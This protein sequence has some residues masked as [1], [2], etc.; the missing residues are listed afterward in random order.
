[1]TLF[2]MRTEPT[3]EEQNVM[4]E[5][6]DEQ[7][8]E[9]P[10]SSSIKDSFDLDLDKNS[11]LSRSPPELISPSREQA[12]KED[13][14]PVYET[15]TDMKKMKIVV[16]VSPSDY[17]PEEP[18]F[19]SD[20]VESIT[21]T[22]ET[23]EE[24][25]E[26][27]VLDSTHAMMEYCSPTR[28]NE[29]EE[30][31]KH[32]RLSIG[33][34]PLVVGESP[35]Q[36]LVSTDNVDKTCN[37]SIIS[38]RE[39]IPDNYAE[40]GDIPDRI[41]P[42]VLPSNADDASA[43][44]QA[45]DSSFSRIDYLSFD[46]IAFAGKDHIDDHKRRQIKLDD[47]DQFEETTNDGS[48]TQKEE[49]FTEASTCSGESTG[50]GKIM[51]AIP[52]P[53]RDFSIS[54]ESSDEKQGD[55]IMDDIQQQ[56]KQQSLFQGNL[57]RGLLEDDQDVAQ[58]ELHGKEQGR[59]VAHLERFESDD[60]VEE[61]ESKHPA[62]AVY[63]VV[64]T[65]ESSGTIEVEKDF[66][67]DSGE[68]EKLEGEK[69]PVEEKL[70]QEPHEGIEQAHDASV[71][72][73]ILER[74]S[75]DVVTVP[76]LTEMQPVN[77]TGFRIGN[78]QYEPEPDE[79][80]EDKTTENSF[81]G[82][83]EV[84]RSTDD[85][86]WKRG[87]LEESLLTASYVTAPPSLETSGICPSVEVQDQRAIY[88]YDAPTY[89]KSDALFLAQESV[90]RTESAS[91]DSEELEEPYGEQKDE[92]DA[93]MQV[94]IAQSH[95]V[96]FE[97]KDNESHIKV[98]EEYQV[99]GETDTNLV[100]QSEKRIKKP[101]ALPEDIVKT[102]S[103][104]DTSAEPTLLAATYDLDSGA[105]S[106][107]VA[108]YDISPDTVEKTVT[109]ESQTKAILSS[110]E[111]DVFES[112]LLGRRQSDIELE[113]IEG[114]EKESPEG[115][116]LSLLQEDQCQ[117]TAGAERVCSPFE[118][119]EDEDL[120]GYVEYTEQ[121]D[122]QRKEFMSTDQAAV[123]GFDF[124]QTIPLTMETHHTGSFEA[125][126]KTNQPDLF[127]AIT[128]IQRPDTFDTV[129]RQQDRQ[130]DY[131]DEESPTF[132]HSSPLSSSEPS[133]IRGHVSPLDQ[134]SL[135]DL[136]QVEQ[137]F[138]HN[139]P[140]QNILLEEPLLS[141]DH[142]NEPY[143]HAN[144]P[145]EVDY[146]PE[147]DDYELQ[148][149][150][151]PPYYEDIE[152][153]DEQPPD[154]LQH[155]DYEEHQD[156]QPSHHFL[157]EGQ[158]SEPEQ[159]LGEA[160]ATLAQEVGAQNITMVHED[161]VY[162]HHA[163]HLEE[164]A[165]DEPSTSEESHKETSSK[166]PSSQEELPYDSI[167]EQ[168]VKQNDLHI[169]TATSSNSPESALGLAAEMSEHDMRVVG[170]DNDDKTESL[171]EDL[172][173]PDLDRDNK[174]IA[175]DHT[176]YELEMPMDEMS[177]SQQL[178][179]FVIE[180]E[181]E[182]FHSPYISQDYITEDIPKRTGRDALESDAAYQMF[183]G[184]VHVPY[185]EDERGINEFEI[186]QTLTDISYPENPE[187]LL[188][189]QDQDE[190]PEPELLALAEANLYEAGQDDML[191]Q[192]TNEHEQKN[193]MRVFEE[194]IGL[195]E[196]FELQPDL[197][198]IERP[199]SPIPDDS[200]R[201]WKEEDLSRRSKQDGDVTKIHDVHFEDSTITGDAELKE[202][203]C[204]FVHTVIE[205]A[206]AKIDE[207]LIS[208]EEPVVLQIEEPTSPAQHMPD[209]IPEITIT[210]H[211]QQ[212]YPDDDDF[213]YEQMRYELDKD[214][215]MVE[216]PVAHVPSKDT[217][218]AGMV[219]HEVD[220][221]EDS[222]FA[223]SNSASADT[224][225]SQVL[226]SQTDINESKITEDMYIPTQEP[227]GSTEPAVTSEQPVEEIITAV[228]TD[229][230]EGMMQ[231]KC[232]KKKN[233]VE[234]YRQYSEVDCYSDLDMEDFVSEEPS[235][236]PTNDNK[237]I[238]GIGAVGGAALDA[239]IILGMGAVG[240]G[241]TTFDI[242]DSPADSGYDAQDYQGREPQIIKIKSKSSHKESRHDHVE[243][244]E[245]RRVERYE[246][247]KHDV[248]EVETK[249][250]DTQDVVTEEEISEIRTL[251]KSEGEAAA[252]CV[253][254]GDREEQDVFTDVSEIH[255]KTTRTEV[256]DK[257]EYV[258]VTTE[259]EDEF[260]IV[261]TE[262][263]EVK[264]T[265]NKEVKGENEVVTTMES[266][267]IGD[268]FIHTQEVTAE[269]K[270]IHGREKQELE[271][272]STQSL[273]IGDETFAI[274]KKREF[275]EEET[276]SE[277][278]E[279]GRGVDTVQM[280]TFGLD[281]GKP[282]MVRSTETFSETKKVTEATQQQDAKETIT[283]VKQDGDE[284]T[285]TER[286]RGAHDESSS[287]D[288]TQA[289]YGESTEVTDKI[290]TSQSSAKEEGVLEPFESES[291]T[292]SS[293]EE[294]TTVIS[295]EQSFDLDDL[296]SPHDEMADSS[297]VDSF[298]TVVA[299][300][301]EEDRLAEISSMTSS[302]HGDLPPPY[303]DIHEPAFSIDV[304]GGDLDIEQD[305]S[306]SG[307]EKFDMLDKEELD[308]SSLIEHKDSP[309]SSPDDS[310]DII[311]RDD[312][313]IGMPLATIT[314]EDEFKDRGSSSSGSKVDI[315]TPDSSEKISTSPVP[316]SPGIL[317][318]RFFS[319]SGEKDD[320]SISSSLL[321]FETL[322]TEIDDKGS[323]ESITLQ[324][325]F[326]PN[327]YGKIT[328]KD[329]MSISSSLAEFER[330]EQVLSPSVSMDKFTGESKSSDGSS[331]SLVEFEKL[332]RIC[333]LDS[334]GK[335]D[336]DEQLVCPSEV[337]SYKSSTSSLAEFEQL[338]SQVMLDQE[339]H[340]EAEKVV[341]MLESGALPLMSEQTSGS[342]SRS[343][344][345]GGST[346]DMSTISQ[347]QLVEPVEITSE[348]HVSEVDESTPITI[349]KD[350]TDRD[351]L[352]EEEYPRY[353]DIV[354]IIREASENVETFDS[355][356]EPDKPEC[357]IERDTH[358]QTIS[359]VPMVE[360]IIET[361]DT[362]FSN[363]FVG[364]EETM[365]HSSVIVPAETTTREIDIDSLQDD[366]SH[367]K[368]GPM[369]SDSLHDQDS[370]MMIST[371]SFEFD[372]V[373]PEGCPEP[374][375]AAHMMDKSMDSLQNFDLMHQSD[376]G[377]G[378]SD[379]NTPFGLIHK[380]A[381]YLGQT[382]VMQ[383]SVDSLGQP[384]IMFQSADSM[385]QSP[386][387]DECFDS[388]GQREVMTES[389]DSLGQ[390]DIMGKSVDSLGQPDI[391]GK[392]VDSLGQPDIMGESVDSLGQPDIMGKSADSLGQPDIMA[393]STDSLGQPDLM[394]KS[395]DSLGQPDPM[396]EST[397]S[398]GQPDLMGKSVD[399]L[400]QPDPMAA[401]V[402][403]LGQPDP[404]AESTDSLGQPDL[405]GK[406]VY[407]LGQPDIMGK[408]VDSLG[409]PDIMAESTDSLGQPDLMEKSVDSLGQA[410]VMQQSVDSL[411]PLDLMQQSV[412]SLGQ[413]DMF[414]QNVDLLVQPGIMMRSVDSLGSPD[415]MQQSTDSLDIRRNRTYR[416]TDSLEMDQTIPAED[417][418]V[419]SSDSL[420]LD[421]SKPALSQES[422]DRDSLP[423]Q[424]VE[425]A[426]SVR[427]EHKNLIGVMEMSMESGAWSQ[428]SSLISTETLKSS[429]TMTDSGRDIMRM[430]ME[431]PEMD[432]TSLVEDK[433]PFIEKPTETNYE[434]FRTLPDQQD[435]IEVY[436]ITESMLSSTST[437][438]S[439]IDPEGNITKMTSIDSEGNISVTSHDQETVILYDRDTSSSKK[440]MTY[441]HERRTTTY[442]PGVGK[443][444]FTVD[445]SRPGTR[446]TVTNISIVPDRPR[447]L[448][449]DL[450]SPQD[451][452]PTQSQTTPS[453][454]SSHSETCYCAPDIPAA[455]SSID[456]TTWK[457]A[458]SPITRGSCP[459][460]NSFLVLA[461]MS[462]LSPGRVGA[463]V[464]YPCMPLIFSFIYFPHVVFIFLFILLKFNI[465]IYY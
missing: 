443:I 235:I 311:D 441:E 8:I 88:A 305:E 268:E 463:S 73:T 69:T 110:P 97:N 72:E 83:T 431:S 183:V 41:E 245:F 200:N 101:D 435:P 453:S 337:A 299:L 169:H 256:S 157:V 355:V 179:E 377:L 252:E 1:M 161:I 80:E 163:G 238:L 328:E 150:I 91:L 327:I 63:D 315:V 77:V 341:S 278:Q 276:Y 426:T 336:S 298:A 2:S 205:E 320:V 138:F 202:H 454:E 465:L 405:M 288:E 323:N 34:A 240:S 51:R 203:A 438:K 209:D 190:I 38:H 462:P 353:Q 392:S 12:L 231:S 339:L 241:T 407:S 297:S 260:G 368:S 397:D 90:D 290:P 109:V 59:S 224:Q 356:E 186:L 255:K 54:P 413:P 85:S 204:E 338:E 442:E 198:D 139:D 32:E 403:S 325:E 147:I 237:D 440:P 258:D 116:G 142:V 408:S 94:N 253:A 391:M 372:P 70:I 375:Q 437:L 326:Q 39:S 158:P 350:T 412:D 354:Q 366:E 199:K 153:M 182:M 166:E 47:E 37:D 411:G 448:E 99:V 197:C 127:D 383:Q 267:K 444:T 111:D 131:V 7:S 460:N 156:E 324:L 229:S 220:T 184:P 43:V 406:S 219:I 449:Q 389:V 58:Q 342:D 192:N 370:V 322:E 387:L 382:D 361:S 33:D 21:I 309:I 31:R 3:Q 143:A 363:A 194:L 23:E 452:S 140:T 62:E 165:P 374:E 130:T 86:E 45:E 115:T 457:S 159:P 49:L 5:Q 416:S 93:E 365:L 129:P 420:D 340:A 269:T 189:E 333:K 48:L 148:Q 281:S 76:E 265:E 417:I 29:V 261:K 257:K 348:E 395:V 388:F 344:S 332:E 71:I 119:V 282:E 402:D 404:M 201:I 378:Q 369:D 44:S 216:I 25:D 399:S 213:D 428:T 154:I 6:T 427:P 117:D 380:S 188:D 67:A 217:S 87:E 314:E 19:M 123:L 446:Q 247:G 345:H 349:E 227:S 313:E 218:L 15:S 225:Q 103:S 78:V 196:H 283:E 357:K 455:S 207:K 223:D 398:L 17:I 317:Q 286:V 274:H 373:T 236:S 221:E 172:P 144:G 400:G 273:N 379:H 137:Q 136:V 385:G 106:R 233:K 141:D 104:S 251:R 334:D 259:K 316:D 20:S 27:A 296:T 191:S 308:D 376:D 56:M 120:L 84:S 451:P 289:Q 295:K 98:P 74:C 264:L 243:Q 418:M 175:S 55:F 42:T 53:M 436:N 321:E 122:L 230:L 82:L 160:V 300:H 358:V 13:I 310:Y 371:E 100:E 206:Q 331:M 301:Q 447:A 409:Q 132:D 415:I 176:L 458:T 26:A 390:P 249:V 422:F 40:T 145:T 128:E 152:Q 425:M 294:I 210:Q 242:V 280:A 9:E 181:H 329:D 16:G 178:R 107:V 306:S 64:T 187:Y 433:T 50:E 430:S 46:N 263:D 173:L 384:D 195:S 351:S 215:V 146:Q 367:S 450:S 396:A 461:V 292:T 419:R 118:I 61:L 271:H 432:L 394:G 162:V 464:T 232:R 92:L 318:G 22:E 108:T 284:E 347:E 302:Y 222:S 439:I 81:L 68:W 421:Q 113:I 293:G 114:F 60:T 193:E 135:P 18:E 254:V 112:D 275:Q 239:S 35:I 96:P 211:L 155:P 287:R 434:K 272:E 65:D 214:D 124:D 180:Q 52:R 66:R 212:E 244:T 105:I 330:L 134:A 167:Q 307:S 360:N 456:S 185:V 36:D 149:E 11:P 226:P 291:E 285:I 303:E 277:I 79:E 126:A 459:T 95:P 362:N 75:H 164:T 174:M 125:A 346:K 304:R 410:Y 319:K 246:D 151:S 270:E 364:A 250:E 445:S 121:L 57:Q 335:Y 279:E 262:R 429:T 266:T 234:T 228:A 4:E 312:V 208:E 24:V 14:S 401:S 10:Y 381:D 171:I 386:V 177:A 133:D 248:Q 170:G 343:D 359:D 424:E 168:D 393:E 30:A 414:S 89:P 423:D 102:S 352:G 28:D